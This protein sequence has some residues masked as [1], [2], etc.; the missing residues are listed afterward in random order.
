VAREFAARQ[1][2]AFAF[3][4]IAG[5]RTHAVLDFFQEYLRPDE[6][7]FTVTEIAWVEPDESLFDVALLRVATAGEGGGQPP[8]AIELLAE[9]A[10][11]PGRWVAV[12]G[13]P[14]YD[15]RADPADQQR[16]FGG[17]YGV[18]RLAAGQ[19]LAAAPAGLVA[20]D[21]S[22]LGGNS[23]SAVIDLST[24]RALALHF[25][26]RAQQRNSAVSARVVARIA[27]DHGR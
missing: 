5:K 4:V 12:I 24:G 13:Y 23:G 7:R 19:V 6:A 20:H 1:D 22:T 10:G 9:D 21:A 3:R 16:I 2:G 14:G 18:K 15:S 25:G 27:R 17:V 8:A 26:G 11:G